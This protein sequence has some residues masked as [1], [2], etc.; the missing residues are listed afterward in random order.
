M[1]L[2]TQK[3][4]SWPKIPESTGRYPCLLKMKDSLVLLD[5][6][7]VQTYNL[8]TGTWSV[9]K[10]PAVMPVVRSG[11]VALSDEE[12]LIAGSWEFDNRRS[13]YI[14]HVS[15]NTYDPHCCTWDDQVLHL[16]PC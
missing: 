6:Y 3:W 1:D 10:G 15:N 9:A 2:D 5:Y 16:V 13:A 7:H 11:C 14:Y 8:T 4:G 12:I